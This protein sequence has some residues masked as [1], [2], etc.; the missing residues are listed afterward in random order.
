MERVKIKL[1]NSTA[2]MPTFAKPGDAGADLIATEKLYDPING[3]VTFKLGIAS[4]IPPGYEVQLRPRSSVY[5]T[6][7]M[8]CNTP[9]T[10]DSGYRG[11]WMVKF[12]VINP[13]SETYN[14]GDRVCQA[15]LCKLPN[16]DYIVAEELSNSERGNGGFGSTN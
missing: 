4:E 3:V 2:K 15:V 7:L 13:G 9:G 12:Y 14:I 11:E 16:V 1:L 10:V 6:G 5:K 8:M